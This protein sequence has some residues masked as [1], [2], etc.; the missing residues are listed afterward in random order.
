MKLL[1]RFALPSLFFVASATS[2]ATEGTT[3]NNPTLDSTGS[4]SLEQLTRYILNLGGYFGYNLRVQPPV[5]S[6][7]NTVQNGLVSQSLLNPS[8]LQ[9][10]ENYVFNSYLG[11]LL[12]NSAATTSFVPSSMSAY[13]AI[14]QFANYTFPKYSSASSTGASVSTLIDQPP[15]QSDPVS[16]AILNI[17]GT[18]DFSYCLNNDNTAIVSCLYGEGTMNEYQVMVNAVGTIP[19]PTNYFTYSQVQNLLSQLNVNTLISPFMYSTTVSE[20]S[21]SYSTTTSSTNQGLTATSQIQQAANFIRFVSGAILPA[22][23]PNRNTY[24]NWYLQAINSGGSYTQMQSLQAQ[25]VLT[26]YLAKLRIYAA[27]SSVGLSNLYYIFSKRIS[28][29]VGT[30]NNSKQTSEAFNEYSM[31][32]WRLYNP[33]QS[34]NKQWINQINNASQ[35]TVEKE[36]AILLAEMNYQL[37]LSRQLQER[38]LLTHTVMLMQNIKMSQPSPSLGGRSTGTSSSTTQSGG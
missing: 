36:I 12:V 27:Q 35:A 23:L 22:P 37:Y 6:S 5:D 30:T 21:S 13:S 14:N 10:V 29:N 28:Q 1:G 31:A 33:D 15:Y 38:M 9:S 19:S 18:P 32:T 16:Q 34:Q 25:A 17:L 11:A 26:D 2:F 7:G 4:S 20:T 3:T 24:E 8:L